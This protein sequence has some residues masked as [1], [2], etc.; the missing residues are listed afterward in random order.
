MHIPVP[1]DEV[2]AECHRVSA[3][4][5]VRLR[6]PDL[7]NGAS[8]LYLHPPLPPPTHTHM[9]MDMDMGHTH[10]RTHIYPKRAP[11]AHP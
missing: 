5:Q 8:L 7:I 6:R 9:D 10:M 11:Y 1:T 3:G 4:R 2:A